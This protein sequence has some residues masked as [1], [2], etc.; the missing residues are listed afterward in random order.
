M[1]NYEEIKKD[2]QRTAK[3]KTFINKYIW[4]GKDFP[5]EKDDWKKCKNV[6]VTVALKALNAKK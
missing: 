2:L 3:F 4:E 5:S 6:N 1:W